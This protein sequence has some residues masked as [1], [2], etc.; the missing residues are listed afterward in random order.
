MAASSGRVGQ[1]HDMILALCFRFLKCGSGNKKNILLNYRRYS[2]IVSY[3]AARYYL[4]FAK[5]IWQE[6]HRVC[7]DNADITVIV[8]CGLFG[9]DRRPGSPKSCDLVGNVLRDLNA[10]FHAC[11]RR[12][13]KAVCRKAASYPASRCR[14]TLAPAPSTARQ[15][16]TRCPQTRPAYQTAGSRR[17]LESAAANPCHWELQDFRTVRRHRRQSLLR[18]GAYYSN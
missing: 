10:N 16:H 3:L 13:V 1:T 2:Q 17:K 11:F 18:E 5:E 6:L 14:G 7:S 4:S 8:V 12:H 15:I 9:C